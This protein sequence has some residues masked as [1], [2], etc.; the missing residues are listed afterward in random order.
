MKLEPVP[1]C[2]GQLIQR[3]KRGESVA[4]ELISKLYRPTLNQVAMRIVRNADDA[5]DAVQETMVKAFRAIKDFDPN[6]P[7][8]PWLCRI[9]ANVSIDMVRSRKHE[10]DPLDQHE[11]MLC[12]GSESL[13]S[14]AEDSI[15]KE[16]V[17]EAIGRLPVKYR[18]IIF[19]RHFRHMDVNEIA[20]ELKAPEGTI[21]SWLF[22]ARG[23]LKRDLQMALG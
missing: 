17:V 10:S 7:L 19:L 4:F 11:Y 23:L 8:K 18:Q 16:L 22:R 12:D 13:S 5:N 6:R 2:E 21:K 1:C 3:A 20:D 15:A 14:Q 9:C